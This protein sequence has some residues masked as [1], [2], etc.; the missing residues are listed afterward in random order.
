LTQITADATVYPFKWIPGTRSIF[1]IKPT[2]ISHTAEKTAFR[3]T[4]KQI[5]Q[6]LPKI[7]FPTIAICIKDTVHHHLF[8]FTR[9]LQAAEH[10]LR[11][12]MADIQ[13]CLYIY[14]YYKVSKIV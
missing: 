9:L 14:E 3:A 8:P 7:S 1:I 13:V 10:I 5:E 6:P 4:Q 11:A 12:L 2:A